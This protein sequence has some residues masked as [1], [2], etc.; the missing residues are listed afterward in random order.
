MSSAVASGDGLP[1]AG[2]RSGSA[3][4]P[5]LTRPPTRQ[6]ACAVDAIGPA[7]RQTAALE[8][9]PRQRKQL[10]LADVD[11]PSRRSRRP[12]RWP[13][14]PRRRVAPTGRSCQVCR[15]AVPVRTRRSPP[16]LQRP[17]PSGEN[18]AE[19]DTGAPPSGR[20]VDQLGGFDSR[21]PDR[22]AGVG[23]PGGTGGRT[24]YRPAA[25]RAAST[26]RP[27]GGWP[28][29]WQAR[30]VAPAR[31]SALAGLCWV[32]SA[33]RWSGSRSRTV[34]TGRPGRR[35]RADEV[36]DE[37]DGIPASRLGRR[38]SP[39]HGGTLAAAPTAAASR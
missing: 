8:R 30:T 7:G 13:A 23:P 16:Q 2:R 19:G 4:H 28:R 29:T 3:P 34:Q 5:D 35:L 37:D 18:Q 17:P 39:H 9:A 6:P 20:T 36:R 1:L 27:P 15:D 12:N 32:A 25:R 26:D 10:G 14:P 21:S 31:P 33:G 24:G 38:C 22:A 11:R